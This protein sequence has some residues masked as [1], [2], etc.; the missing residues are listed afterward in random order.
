MQEKFRMFCFGNQN[1]ETLE[2]LEKDLDSF[3]DFCVKINLYFDKEFQE[4]V[5]K[6]RKS[7]NDEFYLYTDSISDG[8]EISISSDTFN[9]ID[10]QGFYRY[11]II[12]KTVRKI[13]ATEIDS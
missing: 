4:N 8:K 10:E 11:E 1:K 12:D 5:S 7:M 13:L 6:V 9:K 2:R 3:V